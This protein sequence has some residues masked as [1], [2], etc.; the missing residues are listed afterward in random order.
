MTELEAVPEDWERALCVVAHPDDMEY[1]SASAVA[2]WTNQGKTISYC[3]VTSGEAGIDGI[4]PDKCARL[5]QEEER[6]SA[7]VVGVDTVEF[8]AHPDGLVE[9]SIE[10]RRDLAIAIRRHRPDVV[11]SINFRETFGGPG[12]NHA[13]HRATGY[14]LLDAVRDAANRWVFP[15]AGG[16]PWAGVRFALFGGSPHATHG[17]DVTD[18]IERGVDS[19]R[20]HRTYLDGLGTATEGTDPA[21]FVR[22][23]ALAAGPLFGVHA[24]TTFELI[25][26]G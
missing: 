23:W 22:D 11:V 19:L 4:A 7:A 17:V 13:D 12:F 8:L 21:A 5:R 15:G 6:R 16:D 2:R 14:A 9:A 24:A 26:L 3:L 20:E 10:L 1:G 25:P 18:T